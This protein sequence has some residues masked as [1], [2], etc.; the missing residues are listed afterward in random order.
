MRVKINTNR[1]IKSNMDIARKQKIPSMT[2]KIEDIVK[3]EL[4]EEFG[5]TL[6]EE[7][8][9]KIA[10]KEKERKVKRDLAL[11]NSRMKIMRVKEKARETQRIRQEIAKGKTCHH[12]KDFSAGANLKVSGDSRKERFK[13][14][15]I[16]Y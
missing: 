2:S 11:K 14:M 15:N 12:I 9:S 3:A 1:D 6:T 13:K 8:L 7:E 10:Q 4:E 5:P 16:E